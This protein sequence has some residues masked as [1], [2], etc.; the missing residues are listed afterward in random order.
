MKVYIVLY[1]NL[2]DLDSFCE[3]FATNEA[4][5]NYADVLKKQ[6]PTLEFYV[7]ELEVREE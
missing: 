4:A 7:E 1:K 6:N 3:V 2:I 5:Q